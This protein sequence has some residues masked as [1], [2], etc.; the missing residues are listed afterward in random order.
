MTVLD[1]TSHI[2]SI[3]WG[4][5]EPVA[6]KKSKSKEISSRLFDATR[7]QNAGLYFAKGKVKS[8][9]GALGHF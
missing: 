6:K 8:Y 9:N 4:P 1:K 7:D 2:F 5:W 3:F